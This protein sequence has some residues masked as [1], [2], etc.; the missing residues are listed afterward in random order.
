MKYSL[1]TFLKLKEYLQIIVLWIMALFFY[2]F[3]TYSMISDFYFQEIGS[4]AVDFLK[5]EL[6]IAFFVGIFIGTNLFL[7][8]EYVYPRFFKNFGILLMI[9]LRSLLFLITCI[10]G[11]II[12]AGLNKAHYI[13]IDNLF[14]LQL[15]NMWILSFTFY[16]LI[17]YV[18]ITLFQVFRRRMGKNYFESLL[19]GNYMIPVVEYRIFMFLDMYSSTTAAEEAGHYNYSLLLQECFND[20]SELLPKYNAEVYQYVGDEAVLTWKVSEGFDRQQCIEL[21][22]K[23]SIRLLERKQFYQKKFGLKPKFKA[24]VNEGLVTVAEIGQIKTEIAYHGDVLSTAARVRDLCNSFKADLLI[25]NSFYEQLS[26][27]NQEN[28]IVAGT[29]LLRGKKKS[30]TIYMTAE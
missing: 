4:S 8:Q 22:E 13:T 20:L 19:R 12:I 14:V 2:V 27:A 30:V 18:F 7:L 24:S 5:A 16:C 28:F 10:I 26:H 1:K 6:I 29:T 17:V 15:S 25:T 11:L 3:M 9:L 23:F 21:Y